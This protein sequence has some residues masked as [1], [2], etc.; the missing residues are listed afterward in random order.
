MNQ[1]T[2][3]ASKRAPI[4]GSALMAQLID[5]K[6]DLQKRLDAAITAL[7][8]QK[9]VSSRA[10]EA[11][12]KAMSK[13][14]DLEAELDALKKQDHVGI[15]VNDFEVGLCADVPLGAKVYLAAGA[16]PA[17]AVT[18]EQVRSAGGIVHSNG[19]VFFTN[20]EQLNSLLNAGAQPI[21]QP[22]S[23]EREALI[24]LQRNCVAILREEGRLI[25][26]EG[27]VTNQLELIADMLAA[28][29]QCDTESVLIDGIA[30][31]V[32]APVACELLGLHLE[33]RANKPEQQGATP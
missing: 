18:K 25:D 7:A 31:T 11:W 12:L 28:D 24:A 13:I 16:Q 19:N 32:P 5:D 21:K 8:D 33:L 14:G 2:P 4:Y 6:I 10:H 17:I 23:S 9:D 20:L 26:D 30:Y 27:E 3:F 15:V 1:E 22:L 29:A